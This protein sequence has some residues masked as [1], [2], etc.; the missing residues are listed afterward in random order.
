ML[1]LDKVLSR[2]TLWG[3][4]PLGYENSTLC[5]VIQDM[6]QL[7]TPESLALMLPV[8]IAERDRAY[9]AYLEA[10]KREAEKRH[11]DSYCHVCGR[12]LSD[13]EPHIGLC[14]SCFDRRV[15]DSRDPIGPYEQKWVA[16]FSINW[17]NYWS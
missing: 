13:F 14:P 10:E 11:S 4:Y 5:N 15:R 1:A 12:Y 6:E 3:N 17:Q 2:E 9:A 16:G 7:L 8:N